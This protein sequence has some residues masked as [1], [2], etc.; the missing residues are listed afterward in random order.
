MT[1]PLLRSTLATSAAA[2]ALATGCA[3]QPTQL[4]DRVLKAVRTPFGVSAEER[5]QLGAALTFARQHSLRGL[6]LRAAA[7]RVAVAFEALAAR[8]EADDRIGAERAL[9]VAR[10]EVD[11]YRALAG[12]DDR[13]TAVHLE[14]LTL[15]L[16][17]A[18]AL[19]EER[20]SSAE[21]HQP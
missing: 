15:T 14:A 12:A 9:G 2:A 19:V 4:S 5:G 6:E 13:A 20:G 11:R 16:D 18:T 7:E 3:D 1:H 10:K 17:H 21:S 8:V